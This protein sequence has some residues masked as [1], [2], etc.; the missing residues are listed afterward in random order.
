PITDLGLVNATLT[1][2]DADNKTNTTTKTIE[3]VDDI[4]PTV[5]APTV[6]DRTP[7]V[8][9]TTVMFTVSASDNLGIDRYEWDFGD[10]TN[11]T[12]TLDGSDNHTY[13]AKGSFTPTVTVV[14]ENNKRTTVE[15]AS[16]DPGDTTP[17]TVVTFT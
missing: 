15:F 12:T 3:I 17:P 5:S 14:D 16:V 13:R 7:E 9:L 11:T 6:S 10:G 4:P 8:N 2:T 1:V